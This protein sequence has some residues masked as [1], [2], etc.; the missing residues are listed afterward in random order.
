M[1][2]CTQKIKTCHLAGTDYES[3]T[4]TMSGFAG[5]LDGFEYVIK[6]GFG[7]TVKT[8]TVGNGIEVIGG[9]VVISGDALEDLKVGRYEAF[10]YFE[11]DGETKLLFWED[12]AI[13]NKP[14]DCGC[15][16]GNVEFTYTHE[17][18]SIPVTITQAVVN[19]LDF[20]SL[21]PEQKA[22]LKGEKG[23]KGDK[24]AHEWN[25]TSLSF[26]NPDGSMGESV[27]LKGEKGDPTDNF[28][29]TNTGTD[30]TIW[31]GTQVQYAA[32]ITKDP[33]RIYY[34]F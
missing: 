27:N 11:I 29:D 32:I 23:D 33:N 25:G 17:D 2:C 15:G 5:T 30:K 20:D 6:S 3:K 31:I 8:L 21:T 10:F 28:V 12:L 7:A 14:N 16:S 18:V 1:S 19:F 34:I 26:E 22:E 13:S 24:P 4:I 9:N